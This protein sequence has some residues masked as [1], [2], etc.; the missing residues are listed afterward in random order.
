MPAR[1]IGI[2]EAG[3]GPNLGP[4]VLTA[5]VAEGPGALDDRPDPWRDL[6]GA[7]GRR[8][9][10][11]PLLWLDDSKRLTRTARGLARLEAAAT[12]ALAAAGHAPPST[13]DA[14]HALLGIPPV[15]A[16]L[17]PWLPDPS[18]V[19]LPHPANTTLV[20]SALSLRP[21]SGVPWRSTALRSVVVGPR[22]FNRD[23]AA[24][25][26][27]PPSTS[28]PSPASSAGAFPAPPT[29]SPR[30]SSPTSTAAA[31]ITPTPSAPPS[32]TSPSPPPT[33][34]PPSAATPSAPPP[35]P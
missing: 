26:T 14:L 29:A 11:A 24:T 21:F 17:S 19:P 12:A 7:V 20:S 1:W 13:L 34:A 25:R 3:Y 4:L 9:A 28:P 31:T 27:S 16:E 6:P 32:P 18:A 22:R 15:D 35:I 10:S 33:K 8:G 5:V 2:D 30:A 23:L